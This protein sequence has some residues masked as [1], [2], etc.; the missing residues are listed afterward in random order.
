[1]TLPFFYFLALQDI[2]RI[3]RSVDDFAAV[4]D[5]PPAARFHPVT[6]TDASH[7]THSRINKTFGYFGA[8]PAYTPQQPFS[9]R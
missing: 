4:F 2:P 3:N 8:V 6:P 7:P 9:A 5:M 1:M